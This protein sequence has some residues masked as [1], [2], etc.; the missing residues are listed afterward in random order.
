MKKR[1]KRERRKFGR[2]VLRLVDEFIRQHPRNGEGGQAREIAL[3][4]LR[5]VLADAF[6]LPPVQL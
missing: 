3:A 5:H 2:F 4:D 6:R 1:C